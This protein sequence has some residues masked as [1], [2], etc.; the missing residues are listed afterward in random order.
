MLSKT[1][2]KILVIAGLDPSGGAGILLD[3]KTIHYFGGYAFCIPTCLTV[4]NTQKVYKIYEVNPK[5]FLK[6]FEVL[7]K[8]V[9][10]F[11]SVKI[12]ALYSK[13]IIDITTD[14]IKTYKLKNIVLDPVINPTKGKSLLKKDALSSL[15]QLIPLCSVITP[16]IPEA[17][18][19]SGIKIKTLDDMKTSLGK[20]KEKFNIKNIILKGGHL[21]I[22]NE[23]YDL[24]YTENKIIPFKKKY[25]KNK[26]IHGT[27]CLFSSILA[28]FLA[29]NLSINKAFYETENNFNKL[30]NKTIKIGEGQY[31][32]NL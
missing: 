28:F 16:N 25:L 20:I 3:T 10:Q 30:I 11:D 7:I 17:E 31:I 21:A 8:D 29:K 18:F 22:G 15:F 19:L 9:G 5:Y 27:G 32:I 26:N 12:G 1:A 14:L 4:Q 6:T 23:I 2:T 13:K 24:L